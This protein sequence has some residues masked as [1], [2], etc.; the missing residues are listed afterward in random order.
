MQYFWE[1]GETRD[2]LSEIVCDPKP[3][4]NTVSRL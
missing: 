3:A 2:P 1:M 4:R